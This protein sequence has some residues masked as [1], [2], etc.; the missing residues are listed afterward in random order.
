MSKSYSP[1][2]EFGPC[3]WWVWNGDMNKPQML[4]QMDMMKQAG[5]D[6]FYI[7]C[8]QGVELDFLEDEYFERVGWTIE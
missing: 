3:N 2:R 1:F 4:H 7:Y 6:E 5:V 8:E